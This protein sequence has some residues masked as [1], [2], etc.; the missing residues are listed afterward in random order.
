MEANRTPIVDLLRD[1]DEA[2]TMPEGWD[3]VRKNKNRF[4]LEVEESARYT[5]MS[6]G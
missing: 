6:S 5:H 3:Y 2:V 4:L 1:K